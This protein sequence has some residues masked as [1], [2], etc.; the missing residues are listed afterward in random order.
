MGEQGVNCKLLTGN[1]DQGSRAT[2]VDLESLRK[3]HDRAGG[4]GCSGMS[5]GPVGHLPLRAH[6][7]HL[8]VVAQYLLDA[9]SSSR[10]VL[11]ARIIT[12]KN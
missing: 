6:F 5:S 4:S 1:S 9:Y 3:F 10:P 8:T 12:E 7:L 2:S 11:R